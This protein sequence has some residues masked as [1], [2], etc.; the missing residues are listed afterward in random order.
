MGTKI[1]R[2]CLSAL[3]AF[4]IARPVFGLLFFVLWPAFYWGWDYLGRQRAA[5]GLSTPLWN[6]EKKSPAAPVAKNRS[7]LRQLI[8][9]IGIATGALTVAGILLTFGIIVSN[10]RKAK[11][12]RSKVQEGMTVGEVLHSVSAGPFLWANSDAPE[13]DSAN[14]RALNLAPGSE[15]GKFFYFDGSLSKDREIS[16]PEALALLHQRLGDGYRWRV[17][18]FFAGTSVEHFSFKV[19]FDKDGRVRDVTPLYGSFE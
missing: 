3:L 5:H 17:E 15:S 8:R 7:G 4:A 2:I 18:Y 13:T 11:E 1:V 10:E 14:P 19:V 16:E 6:P 12:A 9:A